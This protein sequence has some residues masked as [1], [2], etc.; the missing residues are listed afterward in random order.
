MIS[1]SDSYNTYDIGQYYVILPTIVKWKLQDF[2]EKFKA[3]K[4]PA[5]FN[6]NSK[7]NADFLTVEELHS[8]IYS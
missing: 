1:S 8:L 5:G 3:N 7:E 2:I 6:Y 4:V